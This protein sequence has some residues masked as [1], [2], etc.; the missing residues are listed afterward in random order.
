MTEQEIREG[1][2]A[3]VDEMNFRLLCEAGNTKVKKLI[4][5]GCAYSAVLTEQY[6][7]GGMIW[8]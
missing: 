7:T 6:K 3:L 4:C 5:T 8:Q 2:Q 1:A